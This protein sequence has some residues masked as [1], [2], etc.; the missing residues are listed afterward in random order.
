MLKKWVIKWLLP[1]LLEKKSPQSIPRSGDEGKLVNCFTIYLAAEW[2]KPTY[3]V[4]GFDPEK[5]ELNVLALDENET[6]AIEEVISLD[7]A[8]KYVLRVNHYY[9]LGIANQ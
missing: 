9:G 3:L 2:K 6:F 4:A 7:E 5:D 8:L 1:K